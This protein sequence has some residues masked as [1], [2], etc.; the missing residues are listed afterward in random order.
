LLVVGCSASSETRSST[1]SDDVTN[2]TSITRRA[3]GSFDVVCVDGSREV[4][5]AA[6][7]AADRECGSDSQGQTCAADCQTRLADTTTA[8]DGRCVSY[9]SDFCAAHAAC[10]AD[11]QTRLADTTTAG[12]G[13]CVSYGSDRCGSAM[14]CAAQCD[15]RLSDTDHPGDGRCVSYGADVCGAHVRCSPKCT[16]RLSDGR[17]V[18]YGADECDG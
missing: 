15:T 18:S 14:R 4:D 9:G 7:I 2:V 12:D 3:D 11:C 17:C 6:E 1:Q 10:A 8:G 13:R 16:T 5:T